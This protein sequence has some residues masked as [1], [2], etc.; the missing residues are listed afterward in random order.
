MTLR[1]LLLG[2]ICTLAAP[3]ARAEVL[4]FAAASLKEPLDQIA[5][6]F[7]NVVVSYGGSGTLARQVT[8]G[9]PADI[10]LLANT[11]W[12]DV[13][14]EGGH[15]Q[16]KTAADFASNRLVLV[17]PQGAAP[18]ALTSDALGAALGEGRLAVGLTE[19]VPAGIYTKAALQHLGLWATAKNKLAEVDNV[20]AALALVARGQTPL[21][22]VYQTDTGISDAVTTVAVFPGESHPPIRYTG[23]LTDGAD[24]AAKAVL[25]YLVSGEGQS[26][27]AASGFLPPLGNAQ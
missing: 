17:G 19:A 11:A 9:A 7:D 13:L 10:I 27:L 14:V 15:V 16:P 12:M 21:G 6:R 18:I 25:A 5:A 26:F 8:L 23:A 1:A 20:R 3:V 4:I 2:L 22:V 24:D